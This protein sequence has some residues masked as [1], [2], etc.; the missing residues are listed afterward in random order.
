MKN[1]SSRKMGVLFIA[2][3]L[4]LSA[5]IVSP[6]ARNNI[7]ELEEEEETLTGNKVENEIFAT[8]ILDWNDLNDLRN[9]LDS[10]VVLYNDLDANSPGYDDWV[11]TASGWE[12]I[13]D[14]VDPFTGIFDGNGK[15]ISGL[16]IN[17]SAEEYVGLFGYTDGAEIKDIELTGV[18]VTGEQRVG[19]LVGYNNGL[20]SNTSASGEVEGVSGYYNG[21]LVGY[22]YY[23]GE[24]HFS[25]SSG[26]VTGANG[27]GGL[28]GLNL[29]TISN[30]YST[31]DVVATGNYIGG[32]VGEHRGGIT[33]AYSIGQVSGG[34]YVGGF[35]GWNSG[36]VENSFW[37]N[38]TSGQTTSE[39]GTGK[40][41][42]EMKDVATF[43]DIS[44]DGLDTSWDFFGN[45]NDDVGEED[46][47][48]IHEMINDGYP[49]LLWEPSAIYDWHD[50]DA[51]RND[52]DSGYILMRDLDEN[53][54]GYANYNSHV[55]A[56]YEVEED[57]GYQQTWDDGDTIEICFDDGHYDSILGVEDDV[58]NPIAHTVG[59][60]I[61]IDEDTGERY[62]YVFYENALIGWDPIGEFDSEN[63]E[64]AFTGTFDGGGHEIRGLY[65]NRPGE[66]DVGL[67]G[68]ILE[69]SL[70]EN[71]GLTGS[72]VSG[73]TRVGTLVGNNRGDVN[74]SYASGYVSGFFTVGGLVGR[75]YFRS[76][77]NSYA[78][79]EVTGYRLVGGLVGYNMYG[80]VL[81]SFSTCNV[82]ADQNLVG[83]LIGY[84]HGFTSTNSLTFNSYATGDVTGIEEVGG[85]V[86]R[87][88]GNTTLS[89]CYATGTVTGDSNVG[90]L[91]GLNTY[92]QWEDTFEA[93]S[94]LNSY[95]TGTVS[96]NQEVGGLVGFNDQSIVYNS[97]WDTET[98]GTDTGIGGGD[99]DGATGKTTAQMND[100]STFTDLST[101]GLNE[102]WDFVNNPN[103]DISDED[104]WDID[105]S[106][107]DGYPF[108][109]WN[110][111]AIYDWYDLDGIRQNLDG[112][113]VLINDLD[114]NSAGYED[115]VNTCEGWEPIGDENIVFTGTFDGNG[116]LIKDLNIH[117]PDEDYIGLFGHVGGG[118]IHNMG[119]VDADVTG[120][121][122]TG[123]LAGRS[124]DGSIYEI[125]ATG[126][127][128]GNLNVGGLIGS[129]AHDATISSSYA[130]V[131]VNGDDSRIGGLVGNNWFGMVINSYST[132]EVSGVGE[133]GGLIG[134]NHGTVENSFWDNETSGQTTSEGGTG[135]TTAEMKS[136]ETFTNTDTVGLDEPWDIDVIAAPDIENDY[137]YL[138]WDAGNS[139]VWY[140]EQTGYA[141]SFDVSVEDINAGG[142]PIVVI[143]NAEDQFGGPLDSSYNVSIEIGDGSEV[144]TLSFEGGETSY[145][146]EQITESDEYTVEVTIDGESGSDTFNVNPDDVDTVIISPVDDQ[147]TVT[148]GE[149]LSF[150]AEASDEYGNLITND[151][152][153]FEWEYAVDGVFNQELA[154]DYNVTATYDGVTSDSVMITVESSDLNYIEISPQESTVTAGESETYTV[155]AYDEYWNEIGDVTDGT[156]WDIDE[157]AG[158]SWDANVYTSENPGT[159][160]VTGTYEGKTDETTLVVDLNETDF[161]PENLLLE[162]TPIEGEPPLEVTISVSG[163]NVGD[164]DGSIDVIIAT[165]IEYT[166]NLPAGES[167]EHEFTHTFDE[168]GTYLIEFHNLSETVVVGSELETY[169][170]TVNIVGEGSVHID[171]DLDEFGE[172]TEVTLTATPDEGYEFVEWT[173]DETDTEDTLD[174]TMDEDKTI[175]AVFEELQSE[176]QITDFTVDPTEGDAPLEVQITA[177]IENVGEV[178]GTIMLV[179]NGLELNSWTL[180]FGDQVS[181]DE[182]YIYDEEG[183][184]F[185]DLGEE[186]ITVNVGDVETYTITVNIDGDGIVEISPDRDIYEEG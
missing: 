174:F 169:T 133:A 48:H 127:L 125:Y 43:T 70:V 66:N 47:W 33:N 22:N 29:G 109:T 59:E 75:S 7:R 105:E 166:L 162:V 11:G 128:N 107:N 93:S 170:L 97:F 168:V 103:D 179:T 2:I 86:G 91:V 45:P 52:L 102:P 164:G 99:Q 158:G 129:N 39:G 62:V 106:F 177:E 185:V 143:Y 76:V 181:V 173:G 94:I 49:F 27:L 17:R 95:S 24:V 83:G 123:T 55:E 1:K 57:A 9:H 25:H 64:L 3:V 50:L 138:N 4:F 134:Y 110:P 35:V 13:G 78:T 10:D 178:E 84:N 82:T 172:G 21:V 65:I 90:G 132:G 63:L 113:Y 136:Y 42:E 32:F 150:T 98:S 81:N 144:V 171:P 108:L 141:V 41:T 67:F 165:T 167:E 126:T 122:Y 131:N 104:I 117:R 79:G 72:T 148:A 89:D 88:Y 14:G 36:T 87:S 175:T 31:A 180:G 155:V 118:K 46:T 61:T 5:T 101:S 147:T 119:I 44:T 40:T 182:S 145:E 77:T 96:G 116:H 53:S 115:L 80:D 15:T 135:K 153:E 120:Y 74:N 151:L 186:T 124:N 112:D 92:Y 100:V 56:S 157:D 12:P 16:Y 68:C 69:G 37:D 85:L 26:T 6:G 20:V 184:Y 159:W 160:I 121:D 152:T 114:V 156:D 18:D 140:I 139:P 161:I 60:E 183:L 71:I 176:F 149:D 8:L 28:C 54:A 34:S 30:S 146:W 38:E 163:E 111:F 51:I 154:G 73:R 23:D 19:G 130:N 58:G 137:P 142:Q